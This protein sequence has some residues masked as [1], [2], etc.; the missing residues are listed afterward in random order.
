MKTILTG[1]AFGLVL[2]AQPYGGRPSYGDDRGAYAYRG[3]GFGERIARGERM[4]LL[5]RREAAR[6]WEM[7]RELRVATERAYRSGFGLSHRERERLEHM[8]ARLDREISRQMRDGE[9]DYRGGYG[10]R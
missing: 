4:G 9:R 1:L 2:A 7:E 8:S 6:L 10:R 3:N 5:T